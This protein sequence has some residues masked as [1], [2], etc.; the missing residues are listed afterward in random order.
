MKSIIECRQPAL[1]AI[2]AMG[3][4]PAFPHY[5]SENGKAAGHDNP[6]VAAR[7]RSTTLRT[8][9]PMICLDNEATVLCRIGARQHRL[10]F[11]QIFSGVDN[12]LFLSKAG[13]CPCQRNHRSCDGDPKRL[14]QSFEVIAK[15]ISISPWGSVLLDNRGVTLR[16]TIAMQSPNVSVSVEARWEARQRGDKSGHQAD[17]H[18]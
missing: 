14:E 2:P 5:L 15:C 7:R 6:V 12:F 18:K 1:D 10:R 17:V 8:F 13:T 3:P 11:A 16:K 9:K 4:M